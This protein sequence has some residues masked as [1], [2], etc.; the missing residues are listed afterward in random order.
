MRLLQ[1]FSFTKGWFTHV[2]AGN[3]NASITKH[4]CAFGSVIQEMTRQP[5][6]GIKLVQGRNLC[7]DEMPPTNDPPPPPPHFSLTSF[8][9]QLLTVPP[10]LGSCFWRLHNSPVI[11]NVITV[12]DFPG[13]YLAYLRARSSAPPPP[14]PKKRNF[15]IITVYKKLYRK[16][17]LAAMRSVHLK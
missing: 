6:T 7:R 9:L 12:S 2:C 3:T 1:W 4:A 8:S 13:F 11:R 15:V 5:D 14:P 17:H 10:I 16:S